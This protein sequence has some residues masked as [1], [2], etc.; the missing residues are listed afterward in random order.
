MPD[1]LLRA[2]QNRRRELAEATQSFLAR[3]D[4][5]ALLLPA[6][7][8]TAPRLDAP[9]EVYG[10]ARLLMNLFSITGNPVLVYPG[11]SIDGMPFGMQL[12]GPV[13]TEARLIELA[14][15]YEGRY[16]PFAAPPSAPG[17]DT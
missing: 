2:A 11:G 7:L 17:R 4:L 16:H 15:L 1:S 6:A 5:D 12:V 9:A 8:M 3:E 10:K 13:R 14:G